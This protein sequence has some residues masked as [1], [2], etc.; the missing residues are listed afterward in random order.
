MA[1]AGIS[2]IDYV[3]NLQILRLLQKLKRIKII[4]LFYT[5][6]IIKHDSIRL[7]DTY[8]NQRKPQVFFTKCPHVREYERQ[9]CIGD[10][11]PALGKS[12]I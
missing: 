8:S 2:H 6:H 5:A 3:T 4:S 1:C 12:E 7:R 10:Q 9:K 11:T